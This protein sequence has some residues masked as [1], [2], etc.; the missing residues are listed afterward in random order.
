MGL[1]WHAI[2]EDRRGDSRKGRGCPRYCEAGSELE[3]SRAAAIRNRRM[4]I[5]LKAVP[6]QESPR[7]ESPQRRP[8]TEREPSPEDGL[9][10]ANEREASSLPPVDGGKHAWLFLA[11]CFTIECF[12]WGKPPRR[13]SCPSSDLHGKLRVPVC[14]RCLPELLQHP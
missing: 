14:L 11:A 4:E 8:S 12:V 3:L 6:Q 7:T 10:A 2:G 1:R 5:E 13:R 9:E